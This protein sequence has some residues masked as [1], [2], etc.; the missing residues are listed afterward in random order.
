MTKY[1]GQAGPILV[2]RSLK[3]KMTNMDLSF[4]EDSLEEHF[5]AIEKFSKKYLRGCLKN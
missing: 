3:K 1:E 2:S 5:Q 4:E